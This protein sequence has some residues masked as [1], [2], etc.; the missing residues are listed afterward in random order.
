[1][2]GCAGR[3]P[4][5]EERLHLHP[6][7]SDRAAAQ[8]RLTASARFPCAACQA[9]VDMRHPAACLPVGA[10]PAVQVGAAGVPCTE[11]GRCA[12]GQPTTAAGGGGAAGTPGAR[13][14]CV[15]QADVGHVVGS[16]QVAVAFLGQKGGERGCKCCV[17]SHRPF[18]WCTTD[19]ACHL[20]PPLLVAGS[21]QV[22]R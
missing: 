3:L 2:S 17:Q 19:P 14:G 18:L 5:V 13:L 12:R 8:S 16:H 9:C 22:L 7:S 21:V 10:L 20:L 6:C 11:R 1:M 4:L 15:S